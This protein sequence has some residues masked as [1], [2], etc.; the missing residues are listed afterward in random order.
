MLYPVTSLFS[1]VPF[2]LTYLQLF[3][4]IWFWARCFCYSLYSACLSHSRL[5]CKHPLAVKVQCRYNFIGKP[6]STCLGKISLCFCLFF[7]FLQCPTQISIKGSVISETINLFICMCIFLD[8]KLL[9]S[10]EYF[11]FIV[12]E[13]LA[14]RI[15]HGCNSKNLLYMNEWIR[16]PE[17][18]S[19]IYK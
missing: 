10:T 6:F 18:L 16:S 5:H 11:L 12:S 19:G 13:I 2:I 7:W 17:S 3:K 4:E 9:E 15:N 8:W 1:H 14:Q